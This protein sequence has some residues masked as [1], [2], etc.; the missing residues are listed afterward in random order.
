MQD[1]ISR[2]VTS[3]LTFTYAH[4]N[5]TTY[6]EIFEQGP[7]ISPSSQLCTSAFKL[8]A[9]YNHTDCVS[10]TS[11]WFSY[12]P[13]DPPSRTLKDKGNGLATQA[14]WVKRHSTNPVWPTNG[15]NGFRSAFLVK[16]PVPG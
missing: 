12:F 6:A 16:Y 5:N 4:S 15:S 14:L 10:T 2:H 13:R 8:P 7:S 9:T 3:R 11:D 1:S